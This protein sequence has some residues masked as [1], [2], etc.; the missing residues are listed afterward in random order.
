MGLTNRAVLSCILSLSFLC[1]SQVQ[2][3]N[4]YSQDAVAISAILLVELPPQARDTFHLIKQGGPF[5]YPRDGVVFGNRERQLPL[6]SRNYYREYTVKTPGAHNRG[7][8]RIVC[9]V[10]PECY[11]TGDHYQSFKRIKE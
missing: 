4:H 2:A 7:A 5:P 6:Q 10:V 8:R 1:V 3:R 9:G 11:Y